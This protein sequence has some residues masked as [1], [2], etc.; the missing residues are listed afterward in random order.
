[1][2]PTCRRLTVLIVAVVVVTGVASTASAQAGDRMA[3]FKVSSIQLDSTS[4]VISDT[5][6]TVVLEGALAPGFDLAW[7]L[8]DQISLETSALVTRLPLTAHGGDYA[9]LDVGDVWTLQAGVGIHYHLPLYSRWRPFIGAG[10]AM[11]WPFADNLS[12]NSKVLGIGGVESDPALGWTADAGVLYISGP[13]WSWRFDL[14]YTSADIDLKIM[15]ASHD[16][17]T[18]D[19]LRFDPLTISLG[20]TLRF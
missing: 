18:D 16:V 1:M 8:T 20:A 11:V 6:S 14:R 4:S 7:M 2:A 12:D 9:N 19:T 3:S 15:N 10:V 5:G 17:I 13:N